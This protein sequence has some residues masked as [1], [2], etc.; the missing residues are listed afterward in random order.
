MF[1][2]YKIYMGKVKDT[3]SHGLEFAGGVLGE[4]YLGNN[5]EFGKQAGK[6]IG[7]YLGNEVEK[8]KHGKKVN[9]LYNHIF[10]THSKLVNRGDN[11]TSN[12]MPNIPISKK[13]KR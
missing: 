8:T 5:L 9:D 6:E 10:P 4:R 13:R 3:I 1:F 2:K 11:G 7:N 12:N